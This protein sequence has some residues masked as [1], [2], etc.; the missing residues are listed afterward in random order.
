IYGLTSSQLDPNQLHLLF[1]PLMC[2]YGLALIS[3]I[4]SRCKLSQESGLMGNLHI[5]VI[6]LIASAPLLLQ[7]KQLNDK[8]PHTGSVGGVHAYSLNGSLNSITT[9]KDVIISDQPWAVA[10]Y[11][12]RPAIWL[13]QTY[14]DFIKVETI[15]DK[16][17]SIAGIH[18]S[19]MSYS[20]EDIRQSFYNN[21]DLTA[22]AYLPWINYFVRN[23]NAANISQNPSVAPLIDS[24]I[25]RYPHRTKLSG[26]LE[27]ST[28]YSRSMIRVK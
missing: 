25:G 22:M 15:A 23:E 1:A 12:D 27:P 7:L 3:I 4:W 11:A 20:G 26:L 18:V 8:K 13:P 28:Y 9:P 2:G 24:Q 16:V 14:Y 17:T 10:W 6:I 5:V 21:R 19:S